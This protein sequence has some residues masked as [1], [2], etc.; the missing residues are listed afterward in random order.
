[1]KL[2]TWTYDGTVVVINPVSKEF[3]IGKGLDMFLGKSQMQ[4]E[5]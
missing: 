3:V 2:G 4:N 1:M 5:R